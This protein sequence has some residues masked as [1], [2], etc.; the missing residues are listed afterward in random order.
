MN[1]LAVHQRYLGASV[2]KSVCAAWLVFIG[3][4]A[5]GTLLGEIDRFGQGDY[6]LGHALLMIMLQMPRRAYDNFPMAAVVGSVL[7]IG[8][9][10]ARSELIALRAA[11]LS[12]WRIVATTLGAILLLLVPLVLAGEWINPV[13]EQRAQALRLNAMRSEVSLAGG[14]NV[15]AREGDE[16]FHARGGQRRMVDG[17]PRLVFEQVRVYAFDPEGRLQWIQQAGEADYAEDVG[18]TLRDVQRTTFGPRSA[19]IERFDTQQWATALKPGAIEASLQGPEQLDTATLGMRIDQLRRNGLDASAL[20]DAYWRRWFFPFTT[21]ALVFAAL[22]FAFGQLRSGGFGKRLF[23]GIL[24]A[25]VARLVQP[26]L[27]NLAK[28]YQLPMLLAY[29]VPV[30]LLVA[31]GAAMLRRR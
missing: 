30:L 3:L 25:L 15:W 26:M 31:L 1:G 14:A 12:P 6:G 29:L 22:P 5:I 10:A 8:T 21:L 19:S 23:I 17:R 27:A 28:A 20:L 11:G 16:V 4:A 9:H 2:L 18:W 13:G 7:A 24:F